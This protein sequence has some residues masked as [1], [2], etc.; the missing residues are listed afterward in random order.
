MIHAHTVLFG[1]GYKCG[2]VWLPLPVTPRCTPT[3]G[4][5]VN[6]LDP[7]IRGIV[8]VEHIFERL[9][10][11]RHLSA[12]KARESRNYNA[13]I[14]SLV[15]D[16][17]CGV[18]SSSCP[19]RSNSSDRLSSA[20]SSTGTCACSMGEASRP[21]SASPVDRYA[22]AANDLWRERENAV[23]IAPSACCGITLYGRAIGEHAQEGVGCAV[24]IR[25]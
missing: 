19:T 20:L 18:C 13:M 11:G 22:L 16:A 2:F 8:S 23:G 25:S 5:G 1:D 10:F 21:R 24:R 7:F 14:A 9:P 15:A 3:A 12:P 6:L 17:F 4:G